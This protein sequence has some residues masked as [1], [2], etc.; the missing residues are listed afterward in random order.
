[1]GALKGRDHIDN[2]V[3]ANRIRIEYLEYSVRFGLLSFLEPPH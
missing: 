2:G 1:M 3:G